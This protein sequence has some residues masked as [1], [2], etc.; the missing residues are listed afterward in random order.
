MVRAKRIRVWRR[1]GVVCLVRSLRSLT[2]SLRSLDGYAVSVFCVSVVLSSLAS[3]AAAA[4]LARCSLPFLGVW[5]VLARFARCGRSLCS[6]FVAVSGSLCCPRSLRSLRP[7]ALLAVRCRFWVSGV[8]V[9]VYVSF[10]AV[11]FFCPSVL[12][13]SSFPLSPF[14]G[15]LGSPRSSPFGGWRRF[16]LPSLRSCGS[17]P[18]PVAVRLRF[19]PLLPLR[20]LRLRLARS[21][22]CA[23]LRWLRPLA[24]ALGGALGDGVRLVA[25]LA[26]SLRS[27][28]LGG[29][30]L[31]SFACSLSPVFG[32][33]FGRSS[34]APPV[35]ESSLAPLAAVVGR[36]APRAWGV[37]PPFVG[38]SVV[39]SVVAFSSACGGWWRLGSFVLYRTGLWLTA[40]MV[41]VVFGV[42]VWFPRRVVGGGGSD[43]LFCTERDSGLQR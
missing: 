8:S 24:P 30:R 34:L 31:A 28:S 19:A 23:S 35:V 2:R 38:A 43:L 6:L 17:P 7:L 37:L 41:R 10:V 5:C 27:S 16:A 21:P 26:S 42:F 12:L 18:P 20:S 4:R 11:V 14:G 39:A 25:P 36:S 13:A 9:V 29:C 1:R 40:V 33:S 22:P 15:V 32:R 3:L